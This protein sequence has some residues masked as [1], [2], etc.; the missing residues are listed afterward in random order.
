MVFKRPR[1]MA[2]VNNLPK[3]IESSLRSEGVVYT[4]E[5]N[6]NAVKAER[7]LTGKILGEQENLDKNGQAKNPYLAIYLHGKVDTRGSDF[8]IAAKQEDGKGPL[9]PLLGFWIAEKIKEKIAKKGIKNSKGEQPTVNVKTYKGPY[10]GSNA[11]TALRHGDGT[12]DFHGFGENFQAL[13]LEVGAH[14]RKTHQKELAEILQDLL[15]DFSKEFQTP[16]DMQKLEHYQSAYEKK[17]EQEKD[18]IFNVKNIAFSD[19]I[20]EGKIA[21]GKTPREVLEVEA[22]DTVKIGDRELKVMMMKSADMKSGKTMMM[23]KKYEGTVG[24][25]L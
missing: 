23:N 22:G 7:D 2:D 17:L 10:S 12:F 18:E 24:E 13:Q 14:I 1:L 19:D 25:K 9:N 15:K 4:R 11:L 20:P 8:E 5:D 6:L 3:G 16:K 21:L